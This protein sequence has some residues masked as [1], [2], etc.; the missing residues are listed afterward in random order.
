VGQT[1]APPVPRRG[2]LQEA[3]R[4]WTL[5]LCLTSIEQG[6]LYII[7]GGDTFLRLAGL[8]LIFAPAG[9]VL[10]VDRLLRLWR[11]KERAPVR[12]GSRGRKA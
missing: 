7:H 10:S 1:P 9:A 3:P 4:Y 12:P 6:N 11:K 2:V 5:F 8:F